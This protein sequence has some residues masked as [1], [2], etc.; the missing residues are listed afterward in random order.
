MRWP[1]FS[2]PP[3]TS[4]I[5]LVLG[6]FRG[7]RAKLSLLA[8]TSSTPIIASV[9]TPLRIRPYPTGRLFWGGA[10][11][12]TS[13]QATIAPSLRDINLSQGSCLTACLLIKAP[14]SC[15]TASRR[16]IGTCSEARERIPCVRSDGSHQPVGGMDR[17]WRRQCENNPIN[18]Y[19]RMIPL[20]LIPVRGKEFDA[21][22][23]A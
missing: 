16:S 3:L 6:R 17:P 20:I 4:P 14:A 18:R 22:L 23:F 10:V 11:P 8:Y 9:R 2:T 5:V 13:C 15:R 12:G 21:I 7:V 19:S 1:I